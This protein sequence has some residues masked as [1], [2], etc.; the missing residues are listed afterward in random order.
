MGV[1]NVLVAQ[2]NCSFVIVSAHSIGFFV[3]IIL[4]GIMMGVLSSA[5]DTVLVCY[6][7][8]P[9]ELQE[10]HPDISR[11][12]ETTWATAW[13]DTDFRGIAVVSLG[14]GLGIV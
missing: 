8:A 3:G 6:C 14:G 2:H 7:E 1:Y 4:A 13:P 10:N 11:E 12:L 9:R 5:V